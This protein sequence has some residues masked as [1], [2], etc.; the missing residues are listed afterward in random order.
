MG[1]ANLLEAIRERPIKNLHGELE[2]KR[3]YK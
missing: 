1:V 3:V 2:F